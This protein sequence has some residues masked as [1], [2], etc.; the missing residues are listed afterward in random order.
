MDR[1]IIK[2]MISVL[3]GRHEE[4]F[5]LGFEPMGF[6]RASGLSIDNIANFRIGSISSIKISS[7]VLDSLIIIHEGKNIILKIC[8]LESVTKVQIYVV[9]LGNA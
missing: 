1:L 5:I 8:I 7:T 2:Q 3:I 6:L 4:L 9:T